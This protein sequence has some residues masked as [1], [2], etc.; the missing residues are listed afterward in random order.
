[1]KKEDEVE[2]IECPKCKNNTFTISIQSNDTLRL[3]C[4]GCDCRFERNTISREQKILT[5]R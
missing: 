1:M 4:L 5:K 2:I 3:I